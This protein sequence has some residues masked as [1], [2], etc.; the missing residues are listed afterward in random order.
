MSASVAKPQASRTL[1][2]L[3]FAAVYILWGSTYLAI[4]V[5]V[6]TIPP[7]FMA[8][9]RQFLAGTL[10]FVFLKARGAEW[11][12]RLHW[13]SA[14]MVGLLMLVGGNGFV[15]FSEQQIPSGLAALIVATVP[16]WMVLFDWLVFKGKRPAMQVAIGLVVGFVGVGLLIGPGQFGGDS[17]YD[18]LSLVILL[19]APVLW[20]IGSLYSRRAPLPDNTALGTSMEMLAGGVLLGVLGLATGETARLDI[21]AISSE[22]LLAVLYLI[23]FGSI[24]GFSAFVWLLKTVDPAQVSTNAY[25]NPVVAV[26]LG[27]LIL[28]EPVTPQ[29]LVV[30][31]VIIVAV[32]LITTYKDKSTEAAP[33]LEKL[34]FVPV[35]PGAPGAPCGD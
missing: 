19:L 25:V 1:I 9:V 18:T 31:G 24:V 17:G 7:F 28:G 15:T 12:R 3:A 5:A 16:L 14:A 13:R 2:I 26:F 10:M 21:A 34:E 32:I 33:A 23:I 35:T 22:S 6:E 11:P 8:G 20:A 29:I 27:W 4:S 30:A